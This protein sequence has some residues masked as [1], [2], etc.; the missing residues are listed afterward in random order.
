MTKKTKPLICAGFNIFILFLSLNGYPKTI[1]IPGDYPTIQQGID[2]AV[3]GDTVFVARYEFRESLNF[4]GKAIVVKADLQENSLPPVTDNKKTQGNKIK[5]ETNDEWNGLTTARIFHGRDKPGVTFECGEDN[6]SVID[7]FEIVGGN[8]GIRCSNGSAPVVIRNS[9]GAEDVIDI[10]LENEGT[11]PIINNNYLKGDSPIEI[12]SILKNAKPLITNNFF[13]RDCPYY[14][15][16]NATLADAILVN[17]IFNIPASSGICIDRGKAEIFHNNFIS[18]NTGIYLYSVKSATI[19]DNIFMKNNTAINEYGSKS[20]DVKRNDFWAN[21]YNYAGKIPQD[22]GKLVMVN[23]N[24]DSCDV[25]YNIFMDPE[26]VNFASLDFHIQDYSPGI[27]AG[28]Y[29]GVYWDM[30]FDERPFGYGA[31]IG[32]DEVFYPYISCGVV[33]DTTVVKAGDYL[34]IT[35]IL[36][37][38]LREPKE[39]DAWIDLYTPKGKAYKN[40]PIGGPVSDTLSENELRETYR[41][42]HIPKWVPQGDPYTFVFRIGIYPDEIWDEDSFDL[43]ILKQ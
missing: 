35:F 32:A 6:N 14:Y 8:I 37:N 28:E 41:L 21:K 20:S 3:D 26:F 9:I 12:I 33:P 15:S 30:D 24:G 17:N 42:L 39:F 4:L 2:N 29:V 38:N 23:E 16:V 19:K 40:N 31:D 5:W 27:D 1:H 13:Q 7:G 36:E 22:F 11:N 34:G 25:Y 10:Y 43:K 18:A